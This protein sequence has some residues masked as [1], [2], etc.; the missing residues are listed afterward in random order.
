MKKS[1]KITLL[2]VGA[3]MIG[4]CTKEL[5][6][7]PISS[8]GDNGFFQN[9]QE[10]EAAVIGMYD[11]LQTAIQREFALTE[12]RSDNTESDNSEGE[13]A[14]FE[15]LNVLPT[16]S[17]L[18]RYW[19]DM[20]NVIFRA[21]KVL[22]SLDVV[23]SDASRTQFEAEARFVRAWAHFQLASS[24]GNIPMLD[25]VVAPESEEAFIQKQPTDVYAFVIE[26]LRF[27]AVELKDRGA[28]MEGRATKA[29]AQALLAKVQLTTGDYAGARSNLEAV[30]G[31][32]DYGLME[33]YHDVFY[34]E[35][36]KEIIFAIQFV[37]DDV[38]ESQDFSYEFTQLGKAG[39]N[40]FVTDNF[41]AFM[42]DRNAMEAET[43]R[44]LTLFDP[45]DRMQVGKYITTS[46]D[47]RYCGNDWV[48][49]RMA[50]VYLMHVEA[51]MGSSDESSDAAAIASYNMV[52]NR[53]GMS[54]VSTGSVT[55]QMLLEERR[56][57]LAFENHR[58]QD[59]KRF[60]VAEEVLSAFAADN[61]FEFNPNKLILPIP[62]RALDVSFGK[63]TQNPGY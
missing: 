17:M 55:K 51:I 8:I 43:E 63:L 60:G 4:A 22:G 5:D 41:N 14:Q 59:L 10:V 3:L 52:R 45:S 33:N 39:G 12:M 53:A 29:A 46:S 2:L 35:L 15:K 31:D 42:T 11:G 30:L 62:Q 13:W 37:N 50:D 6:Q 61:G 25:Q 57:E 9:D 18:T 34:S 19:A 16:N 38:N 32:S 56:V 36:N 21:N 28:T 7:S 58:L 47:N 44:D 23:N 1:I 20:Y 49:L 54:T 48:V 24:F 26:D 40:N 27:A